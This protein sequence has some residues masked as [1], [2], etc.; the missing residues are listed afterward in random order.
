MRH[1]EDGGAGLVALLAPL[2]TAQLM[3]ARRRTVRA[4]VAGR[5]IPLHLIDAIE[6]HIQPIAALVLDHGHFHRAFAD[7]DRRHA[8]IDADAVF[9]MNDEVAALQR[10][11]NV[12]HRAA[13]VLARASDTAFTAEDFVVGE[14]AQSFATILRWQQEPGAK[15][16]ECQ[17]RLRASSSFVKQFLEPLQLPAVVAENQC[18]RASRNQFAQRGHVATHT[19]RR[20]QREAHIDSIE[21]R[22]DDAHGAELP[23]PGA[24]LI[25]LFEESLAQR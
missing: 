12:Q 15:H 19:L 24:R 10:G 16:T 25:G 7:E 22:I 17:R 4:D 23:Q 2:A 20:A 11:D 14:N 1:L 18:R 13:T 8:A 6:R 21:R 9:E 5:A 3:Q